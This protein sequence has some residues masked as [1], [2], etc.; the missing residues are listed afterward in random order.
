[1]AGSACVRLAT[2]TYLFIGE[3]CQEQPNCSPTAAMSFKQS[4]KQMEAL[5][6][7]K[8]MNAILNGI[9]TG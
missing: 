9:A 5:W 2:W 1:M 6:I 7:S 4:S 8:N 3:I